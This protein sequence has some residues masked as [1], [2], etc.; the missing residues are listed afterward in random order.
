MRIIGGKF[1][2]RVFKPP[3]KK[4]ST[5]PT[6]DKAKEA[7]Y[8]ILSH[9]LDLSGI[10]ALDLFSGMGNHSYELISRGARSVI[11]V[12]ADYTCIQFIKETALELGIE[13][14]LSPIKGNVYKFLESLTENFD[15]IIADPPYND[16]RIP[17]LPMLILE[18][19]KLLKEDGVFILEHGRTH[20]FEYYERCV[21]TRKYGHS[22]F[23]FFM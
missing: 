18:E 3:F 1:S 12:E 20:N 16:R 11:S 17:Q 5:R 8:S 6:T 13:N 14:E 2:G 19:K 21:D 22:H 7:I 4:S 15:L 10:S 23:S 9:K